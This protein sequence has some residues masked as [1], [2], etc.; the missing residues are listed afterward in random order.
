MLTRRELLVF[1]KARFPLKL[2]AIVI[3][4]IDIA[5]CKGRPQPSPRD[6][7]TKASHDLLCLDGG[8]GVR[9]KSDVRKGIKEGEKTCL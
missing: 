8:K 3:I 2:V 7:N 6:G 9:D 5:S 4:P 1:W